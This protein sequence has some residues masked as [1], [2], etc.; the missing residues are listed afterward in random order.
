M[1][2]TR[3]SNTEF[4]I[5]CVDDTEALMLL[6]YLQDCLIDTKKLRRQGEDYYARHN[7]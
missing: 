3:L 7:M 4:N 6:D 1:R 2:L 5:K